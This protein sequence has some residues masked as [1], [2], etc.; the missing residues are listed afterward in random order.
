MEQLTT[1]KDIK[2]VAGWTIPAGTT[3][4]VVRRMTNPISGSKDV[5]V[6]VDNGTGLKETMPKTLIKAFSTEVEE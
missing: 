5:L 1:K 6:L 3:L 4:F 2:D